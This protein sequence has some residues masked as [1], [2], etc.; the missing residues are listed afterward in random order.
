MET[1]FDNPL[2]PPP[3]ENTPS[4]SHSAS[5]SVH[6][7]PSSE[8]ARKLLKT[9]DNSGEERQEEEG[10]SNMPNESRSTLSEETML[11]N[12]TVDYTP[13]GYHWFHANIVLDKKVWLPMSFKDSTALET[14]Y[15]QNA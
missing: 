2:P 3:L 13:I 5:S 15:I 6:S 7:S 9:S 14:A 4:R 11:I 8:S 1:N 10:T 12:E